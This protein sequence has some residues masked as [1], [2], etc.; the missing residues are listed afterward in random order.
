MNTKSIQ[1][2]KNIPIPE[3]NDRSIY[4][5]QTMEVSDSFLYPFV[6][7]KS[8][9]NESHKVYLAIWRFKQKNPDK[10]FITKTSDVGVRVWRVK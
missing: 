4:P 7:G 1:I 6:H 5:F 3:T 10:D 9:H 2:Q 8:K